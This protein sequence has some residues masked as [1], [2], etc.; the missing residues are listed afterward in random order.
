MMNIRVANQ[1][2]SVARTWTF[3]ADVVVDWKETEL[4]STSVEAQIDEAT[5]VD[6]SSILASVDGD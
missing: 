3:T 6:L 2:E 5:Q 1:P 4:I